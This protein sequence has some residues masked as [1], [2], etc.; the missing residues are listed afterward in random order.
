M[1]KRSA[2]KNK[3]L[4]V[5]QMAFRARKV[6]GTFE[7]RAPG[8]INIRDKN[9]GLKCAAKDCYAMFHDVIVGMMTST[10]RKRFLTI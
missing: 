5:S 2:F 3:R 1:F 7:K 4:A 8:D 9:A 6:F 10:L